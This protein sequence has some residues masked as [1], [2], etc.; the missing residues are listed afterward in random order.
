LSKLDVLLENYPIDEPMD[1]EQ[2]DWLDAKPVGKEII[3]EMYVRSSTCQ[4]NEIAYFWTK[5]S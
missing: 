3:S 4:L 1:S 5:D 2:K